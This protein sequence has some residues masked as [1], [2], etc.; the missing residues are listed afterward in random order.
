MR[1]HAVAA[2]LM[3]HPAGASP[4]PVQKLTAPGRAKPHTAGRLK[5]Q[6]DLMC[7]PSRVAAVFLSVVLVASPAMAGQVRL[8]TPA[9]LQQAIADQAAAEST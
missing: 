7:L 1:H 2:P 6:E 5:S 9:L 8:V 3:R 4:G